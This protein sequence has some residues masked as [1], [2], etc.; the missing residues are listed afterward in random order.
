MQ[1]KDFKSTQCAIARSLERV[2]EWWSILILRDAFYGLTRFD[3]FQRSLGIS[4]NI[5]TKRLN[6]LVQEGLLKRQRYQE[7]PIRYEYVLTQTGHDFW[8]VLLSLLKWGNK[9]FAK[10]GVAVLL[11]D[12]KTGTGVDPILVDGKSGKPITEETHHVGA[13]HSASIRLKR[14]LNLVAEARPTSKFDRVLLPH[15]ISSKE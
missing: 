9:Y 12:R 4:P 1:R 7:R 14:R 10:E 3:E 5:L 11:M 13:T 2:G 6:R 8:P 15:D